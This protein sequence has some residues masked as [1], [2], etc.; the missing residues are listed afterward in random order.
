MTGDLATSRWAAVDAFLE[1]NRQKIAAA[2][3]RPRLIFALDATASR[4]PTWAMARE[5]QTEMFQE[6]AKIGGLDAQLVFFRGREC[7][8]S[9]WVSDAAQLTKMMMQVECRTGFTQIGRVLTHARKENLR[10][11]VSALVFV[12]DAM[13][14]APDDLYAIAREL[15]LPAFMFQEADYSAVATVYREIAHLTKGA[16]CS[17]AP[18]AARE[19]AELLRAVAV[20]AAG[21]VKALRASQSAGAVKLLKHLK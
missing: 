11:K 5:L 6:A 15:G 8:A 12:G 20:Y 17:F 10:Q 19:L 9:R 21:G 2:G 13:E 16:Y 7:Q 18:G 14:E 3:V 1:Q 4:E